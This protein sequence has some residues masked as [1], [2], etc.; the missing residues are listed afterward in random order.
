MWTGSATKKQAWLHVHESQ[1]GME[2]QTPKKQQKTKQLAKKVSQKRSKGCPRGSKSVSKSILNTSKMGSGGGPRLLGEL[3]S[4]LA[5][6]WHAPWPPF[7]RPSDPKGGQSD[8]KW[9]KIASKGRKI[10]LKNL[11]ENH[12]SFS[13]P[14]LYEDLAKRESKYLENL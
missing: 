7:C 14:F 8:P 10:S 13:Y 3:N 6:I 12:H 5:W 1:T 2:P 11:C 9:S 4:I